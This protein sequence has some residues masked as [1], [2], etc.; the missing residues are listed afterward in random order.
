MNIDKIINENRKKITH[1]HHGGEIYGISNSLLDFSININPKA[2]PDIYFNVY[3]DSI[4]QIPVYPDSYSTELKKELIK[5]FKNTLSIENLIIGA[6]SMELISIFCDMFI[7]NDDD[8]IICQPTFSEYVWA[9]KKNGGNVI[10]VYRKPENN[11]R[12]E[13][14]VIKSSF[15]HNTKAIFLC[16]PNNPNGLLDKQEDIVKIIKFASEM[17]VLIFL[18]EAFIE[19][20]GEINSLVSKIT[21]FDNLFICRSFTKFFGLTGL[22][23][24]FG[25]SS[26]E[27]INYISQG[28]ILW[29]VNCIG[30]IVAQD[31]LNSPKFIKDSLDFLSE[32]KKYM[33]H[34]LNEIPTVKIFQSH[35]N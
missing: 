21:S 1:T 5:Y 10:N 23:V 9:V 3:K 31:I 15:S 27:I 18:D 25:V 33:E 16:N 19:F 7:N 2:T 17:D 4:Y 26:P 12:I 24:G 22:R 20:T 13:P 8:V 6:G 32:E 14:E 11:F 30:Q 35:A 28:Q 29:P 34:K